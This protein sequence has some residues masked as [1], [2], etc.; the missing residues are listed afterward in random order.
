MLYSV[1]LYHLNNEVNIPVFLNDREV[2]PWRT[3]ILENSYPSNRVRVLLEKSHPAIIFEMVS[4]YVVNKLVRYSGPCDGGVDNCNRYSR[5]YN[6]MQFLSRSAYYT[7]QT[8][9]SCKYA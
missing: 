5:V 6:N 3:R 8:N 4:Y 9:Y 2:V 1:A 7:G